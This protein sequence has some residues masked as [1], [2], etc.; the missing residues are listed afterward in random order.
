MKV[1]GI[2]LNKTG[3]SSLGRAL[4]KIGFSRHVGC[5]LESLKN[6]K[7]GNLNPIFDLVDKNNCFEDW[8][9]PLMYRELYE[10][11]QDA[12]FI[13]TT[14]KTPDIWYESLCKHA[15]RKGP[16]EHRKLAY[17]HS[18]PHDYKEHHIQFYLD[19]NEEVIEFF[20]NND[21]DKLLVVS[22]ENG[23]GWEEICDFLGKEIPE[24]PFPHL[25]NSQQIKSKKNSEN[26]LKAFIKKTVGKITS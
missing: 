15:T 4:K 11:Y 5:H 7:N 1:F 8:P 24:T 10:K 19:H 13:L 3:T 23:D 2:G 17:G 6:L 16:T 21:P 20:E 26:I 22:W 12:K 14:R 9:W 25:H 18:M